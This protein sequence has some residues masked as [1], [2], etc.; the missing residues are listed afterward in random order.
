MLIVTLL[1][2]VLPLVATS[3]ERIN[4]TTDFTINKSLS[5]ED[6]WIWGPVDDNIHSRTLAENNTKSQ[7][8]IQTSPRT[9]VDQN[10]DP[11]VAYDPPKPNFSLPGRRIS[12]VKCQEYIWELETK[13]INALRDFKCQQTNPGRIKKIPIIVGGRDTI[14]GEFLHM[15]AIGW[16]GVRNNWQFKC[17]GSLISP[18]YILTAAHCSVASASDTTLQDVT[19][20]I[21]RLNF[22]NI[23]FV[24]NE[25][26]LKKYDVGL[27]RIIV[28]PE[29][30]PPNKYYDI[31]LMELDHDVEFSKYVFP[32]CLWSKPDIAELGTSA[33][34]T[35]W[36]ALH[37]GSSDISP[38]LQAG[39][40]NVID[41][42]MCDQLL[43]AYCNRNWCGLMD[44]QLCA[45]KLTGGVDSCQ[46]DSGGPLQVKIN[47]KVDSAYNIYHIIGVTSFG[48]GCAQANTPGIYTRV[49]S[50]I[51]WIENIV[52]P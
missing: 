36:G 25:I 45:G 6:K 9:P 11:C 37:E 16:K 49:S 31:A 35:G 26:R 28:H 30:S 47:L 46:G 3:A 50:F 40:V 13:S 29:Y 22:R 44:H 4:E 33:T 39:D 19:P 14:P 21:V 34:V 43:Q 7:P 8:L 48:I 1:C 2:V 20:K 10:E 42:D 12:E 17:G 18:S 23:F 41:S 51:D 24:E 5:N 27:K 38:E 15:G 52:W 32:S